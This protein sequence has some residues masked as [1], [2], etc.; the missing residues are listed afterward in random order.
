MSEFESTNHTLGAFVT[1]VY[2]IGYAFGPLVI[3]PLSELHGRLIVYNVCNVLFLIWTIACAVANNLGALIVF[4]FFA[5]IASSCPVTL[6]AGT[7]ADMVVPEK[8][9]LAMALWIMGPMVGPTFGPL[10]MYMRRRCLCPRD[11]LLTVSSGWVS[12]RCY[13]VAMDFLYPGYVCKSSF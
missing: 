7:I 2:L 9:G 13:G 6:G 3:A 8:R 12:C 5:G 11:D 4:R 1:S 10:G